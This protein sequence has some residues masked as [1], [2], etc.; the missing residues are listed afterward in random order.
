MLIELAALYLKGDENA[1]RDIVT[2]N[3]WKEL[4]IKEE[5]TFSW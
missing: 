1:P 5:L 2:Y 3:K 4:G